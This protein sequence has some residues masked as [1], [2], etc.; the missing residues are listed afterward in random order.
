PSIEKIGGNAITS[1]RRRNCLARI[2][3]FFDDLQPLLGCPPPA[4]GLARNHF[5]VRYS[6]GHKPILKPVLEPFCLCQLSVRNGGSSPCRLDSPR[7]FF[8][9]LQLFQN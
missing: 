6:L 2:K 5:N 7:R 8:P 9:V 4:A 3:T 1:G